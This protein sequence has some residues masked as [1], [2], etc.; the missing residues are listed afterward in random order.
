[1]R[2]K[3]G[4]G[5][6]P[7]AQWPQLVIWPEAA[8]RRGRGVGAGARLRTLGVGD[9]GYQDIQQRPEHQDRDMHRHVALRLGVRRS[10]DPDSH[11]AQVERAQVEHP[12]HTV[13]R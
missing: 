12:F 4:T 7:D 3:L 10:L 9:A 2:S 1:M 8:Q 6:A 13:K 11:A 5:D